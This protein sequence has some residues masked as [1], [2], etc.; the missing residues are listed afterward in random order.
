MSIY[1]SCGNG[2]AETKWAK[3]EDILDA[4]L[5]CP[6][7]S[8]KD[9][10]ND[11]RGIGRRV[12]AVNTAYPKVYPDIWLGL[13]KVECFDRRLWLEPFKKVCRSN[14][15]TMTLNGAPIKDMS[16]TYFVSMSA[17]KGDNDNIFTRREH[18]S[19][20]IWDKS[21]LTAAIHLLIWMGHKVI[22]FVGCDLGGSTDYYDDRKLSSELHDRNRRLYEEQAEHLKKLTAQARE[23]G[24]RFISCTP[25]SPINDYMEYK[26]L[27]VA[28]KDSEKFNSYKAP[29]K[30]K[31]I[32]DKTATL[33]FRPKMVHVCNWCIMGG[34]QSH[35]LEL[36]NQ[37]KSYK[38]HVVFR[39]KTTI[40]NNCLREFAKRGIEVS[41]YEADKF[42]REDFTAIAGAA[43]TFHNV[44]KEAVDESKDWLLNLLSINF[45]HGCLVMPTCVKNVAVSQY[46][47]NSINTECYIHPPF[48]HFITENNDYYKD[49]TREGA[50]AVVGRV[51]SQ[52]N[53]GG[54][55]YSDEFLEFMNNSPYKTFTV[56]PRTTKG[57]GGPIIPCRSHEYMRNIDIFIIWGDTRETWS[58]AASEANL[59][60]IP[61]IAR[62]MQDGLSEQLSLSKGGKLVSN[63][64]ELKEAIDE[65]AYDP[66]L[67]S[68]VS[69]EGANYLKEQMSINK[70]LTG[71]DLPLV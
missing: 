38:H 11:I 54:Q 6:G 56:G 70:L 28:L 29:I 39:Y 18:T 7:P 13:D 33:D 66:E 17:S 31:H 36:A 62:D 63:I 55:K 45:F 61:V 69:S 67:R 47:Q 35:I 34:V 49:F 59:M 44:H 68:I 16:E 27:G 4:Y 42:T 41:F 37:W 3:S 8:L 53:I 32:V 64:E 30:V 25:N 20:L 51:Q 48:T 65:F 58:L 26:H 9:V 10:P 14:Y 12:L 60:G 46:V 1:Y 23:H 24:I 52:T 57:L 21:S 15:H 71:L 50:D 40:H 43:I 2:L 22:H 5:C 19:D